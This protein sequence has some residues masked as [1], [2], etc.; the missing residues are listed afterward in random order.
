MLIHREDPVKGCIRWFCPSSPSGQRVLKEEEAGKLEED[1]HRFLG[2]W[3]VD[4]INRDALQWYWQRSDCE[5]VAVQSVIELLERMSDMFQRRLGLV[6]YGTIKWTRDD[7]ICRRFHTIL[8]EKRSS[9]HTPRCV[10]SRIPGSSSLYDS[11][12]ETR[13]FSLGSQVRCCGL[14]RNDTS[15]DCMSTYRGMHS[16]MLERDYRCSSEFPRI[17]SELIGDLV[18]LDKR[19]QREVRKMADVVDDYHLR[20]ESFFLAVTILD[21]Y[22]SLAI[23]K[24]ETPAKQDLR[25]LSMTS[26]FISAKC[27][28]VR[29]LGISV[30]ASVCSKRNDRAVSNEDVVHTEMKILKQMQYAISIPTAYD[31]LEDY[32]VMLPETFAPSVIELRET[33]LKCMKAYVETTH[34]SY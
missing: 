31:F 14:A 2:F 21:R 30:I 32:L 26:L 28:D 34:N 11:L 15:H 19:R 1:A 29:Y 13:L 5:S 27:R 33:A 17:P 20:P 10:I 9:S 4:S 8:I 12:L 23:A 6:L 16:T 25:I 22:L 7:W 18:S 24:H 3:K